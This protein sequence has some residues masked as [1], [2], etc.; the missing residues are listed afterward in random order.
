MWL[1]LMY[2]KCEFSTSYITKLLGF[3]AVVFKYQRNLT[4]AVVIYLLNTKADLFP[5][6]SV[7][8]NALWILAAL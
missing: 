5:S 6:S 8:L 7:I 2:L 1:K 3:Q 4:T